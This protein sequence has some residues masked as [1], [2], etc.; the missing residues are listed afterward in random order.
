LFKQS[1]SPRQRLDSLVIAAHQRLFLGAGPALELT[2]GRD[3]IGDPFEP[4]RIDQRY[5][6]ARRGV[7]A[8]NTRVVL[9]DA[10]VESEPRCPDVVAGVSA[11]QVA[12][13]SPVHGR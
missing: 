6:P 7:A 5:R 12:E 3:G 10:L 11:P 8:E 2:F 1:L 4:L 9:C 13:V